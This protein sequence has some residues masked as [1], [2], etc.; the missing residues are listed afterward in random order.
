[1][2]GFPDQNDI[3]AY[4]AA[5]RDSGVLGQGARRID[6]LEYLI[7]KEAAGEGDEIKAFSIGLD[8]FDKPETFDPNSDS[9]V[10]VEVS[11]LRGA[12]AAFAQ[13]AES[14]RVMRVEIPSGS[15]RPIISP[16]SDAA[17]PGAP[18]PAPEPRRGP[19]RRLG[20]RVAA[21]VAV[22]ALTAAVATAWFLSGGRESRTGITV[23]VVPDLSLEAEDGS[24]RFLTQFAIGLRAALSRNRDLRVLSSEAPG[25]PDYT[26]VPSVLGEDRPDMLVLEVVG[27]E[28]GRVVWGEALKPEG[29]TD[30]ETIKDLVYL[31]A[32]DIYPQ[33][34]SSS[35]RSLA[36]QDPDALNAWELYLL[37]TWVPGEAV[38]ALWWEEE[39]LALARRAV[40]LDPELGPAHSVVA[41]KLIYLSSVDADHHSEAVEAEAE[42]AAFAAMGYAPFDVTT[43]FNLSIYRW[44]AG[45]HAQ[46]ALLMRRVAEIDPANSLASLLAAVFPFTCIPA[47]DAILE[48]AR[49]YDASLGADNP[50]RWVTQTWLGMLHLNRGELERAAEAEATAATVFQTP[51]TAMRHAVILH[52]LGRTEDAAGILDVMRADWP[53]LD[54]SH[55]AYIT[56]PRRCHEAAAQ[57][58]PLLARYR[59][60]AGAL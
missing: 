43:L 34:V 24:D 12:L 14:N 51:D 55:F 11:R 53:N 13:R 22:L 18:A 29:R 8:V 33:L 60:L 42:A 5:I 9:I 16:P 6:L 47:P 30:A 28:D 1:M 10:R 27:T 26:I 57:A 3:A 50:V 15:Y 20:T 21:T 41:D 37:A 59:D 7:R 4:L 56:M 25:V 17:P 40:A 35:K 52:A 46:A 19:L 31:A 32:R 49:A 23:A 36:E 38:S 48:R 44:H 58:D 2:A 39:R 45:D 54:P